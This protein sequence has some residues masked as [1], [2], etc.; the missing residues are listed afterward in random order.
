MAFGVPQQVEYDTTCSILPKDP[1]PYEWAH[2]S[3]V[4]FLILLADIN[5]CRDGLSGARDWKQMEQELVTWM[6]RPTQH[7]ETWESWMIVAWVAVQESWR[8]TLLA[9][10]YMVSGLLQ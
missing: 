5:A 1:L 10:L 7:N 3:P 8:L 6:G 2:S 4:E 9:Y